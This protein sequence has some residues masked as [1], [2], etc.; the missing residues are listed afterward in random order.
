VMLAED[1][2]MPITEI[3]MD[4]WLEYEASDQFMGNRTLQGIYGS[5][6][7]LL[8]DMRAVLHASENFYV[9]KPMMELAM[10]LA[11]EMPDEE[12]LPHDLPALQG[13][14]WF[15]HP[16]RQIDIRR[17]ILIDHAIMWSVFG[18]QVRVF[19]FTDRSD[20]ND[21]VNQVL[22]GRHTEEQMRQLPMLNLNHVFDMKFGEPLPRG[23]VWDTPLPADAVVDATRTTNPDGTDT[24]T[25][26]T[27]QPI[28]AMFSDDGK[29]EQP[30]YIRSPLAAFIVTL[31]RL[32]QQSIASRLVEEPARHA[33][34]RMTKAHLPVSPI[35][36]INLRR[37]SGPAHDESHVDWQH[38]WV[39]RG[40]WRRQPY[41][42][43]GEIIHRYIY[44]NPYLKGPED[45]PLLH[46]DKVNAL[47]R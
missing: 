20:L 36:V 19:H 21:S 17:K 11:D 2:A 29:P 47:I 6:K 13:W 45:K 40:H 27:D 38:R 1:L 8:T 3:L 7:G 14:M 12:L 41:K 16:Y 24:L 31:W 23:I 25:W 43:N 26:Y 4:S 42:E 18:G 44:I 10:A 28:P 15:A 37:I 33:R 35:T 30:K 32:C 39:V 34:R 46:R 22:W 9:A 5:G